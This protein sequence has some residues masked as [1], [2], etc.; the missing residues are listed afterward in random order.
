MHNLCCIEVPL[1]PHAEAIALPHH[2]KRGKM[3]RYSAT[4]F[5]NHVNM[6]TEY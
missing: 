3:K 5:T 6:K 2:Y 4:Q 1:D